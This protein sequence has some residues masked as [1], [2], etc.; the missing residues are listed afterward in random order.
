MVQQRRSDFGWIVTLIVGVVAGLVVGASAW[1][2]DFP[3][4]G[5]PI[6]IV[7]THEAGGPNDSMARAMAVG[8]EKEFGTPVLVVNKPGA[9]TQ[10]G[11][12]FV[13]QAKPDG[14][15]FSTI[16][17]PTSLTAYLDPARKAVYNR[18]SFEALAMHV[19]DPSIMAVKPDSPFKGV[20]D[21]VEAAKAN[22]KK[23]T[24]SSGLMNDDQFSVLML[25]RAGGAQLAQ[26]TFP[27]GTASSLTAMMGGKIDVFT[28][29]VGD[30]RSAAKTGQA[31]ML[32]VMD[33]QRSPFFPEVKTFEEQGF[34]VYNSS[35]RGY[36]LPAGTP[37]EIVNILA[38]AMKKVIASEEHQKR[39][40]EMG[41]TLRYMGPAEFAKYWDEYEKTT[42]EL[43]KL[44][45]AQ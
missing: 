18:K 14:Y 2:V 7:V 42:I 20:K 26:V 38:E 32:G 1:A 24:V 25:E 44:A 31:R 17:F 30:M 21:L 43:I 36:V 5:K 10:V 8:L 35:S 33:N 12:T 13:A 3:Q 40:T 27:Q 9:S 28:G 15:T 23:V 16:T 11:M 37:K 19:W 6:Q 29:N 41:V 45:E 39:M 22:P 34:K 4:K